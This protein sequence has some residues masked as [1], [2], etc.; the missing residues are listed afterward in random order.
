MSGRTVCLLP[1]ATKYWGGP[2]RGFWVSMV[3]A[4]LALNEK[5][6]G[7]VQKSAKF[8]SQVGLVGGSLASCKPRRTLIKDPM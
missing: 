1:A 3:S 2:T 4:I 8:Q 7:E 6:V 5:L